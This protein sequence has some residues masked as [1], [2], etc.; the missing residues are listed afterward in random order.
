MNRYVI[1]NFV[2]VSFLNLMLFVPNI[3]FQYRYK[4]AVS[5][6]I[7]AA[8]IGTTAALL[9]I[10]AMSK[11]PSKGVP[12]ILFERHPRWAVIPVLIVFAFMWFT[13]SSIALA[14]YALL[15]NRFF[16]PDANTLVILT[17][18]AVI[19]LYAATRS[20]LSM[21]FNMEIVLI[22]NTPLIL[23][24]LIKAARSN[25]LLWDEIRTASNYFHI[26]PKLAPIAAATFIFTGY[27]NLSVYNRAFPPNFHFRLKWLIP[28]IGIAVLAVSYFVPI[29][30][31][32]TDG[33]G[34]Y[35][36][37]W[38]ATSDSLVM[39]YG[40]IERVLFVFL[41]LYLNLT[42]VYTASGWHQAMEIVKS[43]L[44]RY[45]LAIDEHPIPIRN[46][47]ICSIFAL[48]TILS[49]YLLNEKDYSKL[50][51]YWLILRM[52]AEY[53]LVIW[54]FLLSLTRRKPT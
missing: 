6:L 25:Q 22:V 44:P 36:Y 1:Y 52:I 47:V 46:Y 9:F 10:H 53:G 14:G 11:F 42:L 21:M 19:C 49:L 30:L 41:I 39:E 12:E 17:I 54:I 33:V 18:M 16:N 24:L 3:L 5:S 20:T 32:G 38:T 7:V 28:T 45:K 13:A 26:M 51:E 27:V 15:I 43:C 48:T 40:F 34:S 29:G 31:H 35:L 8:L 50:T 37:V 2:L 4:G 23:L